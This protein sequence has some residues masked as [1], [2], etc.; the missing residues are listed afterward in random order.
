MKLKSLCLAALVAVMPGMAS[1]GEQANAPTVTG[2]TGLFT[3]VTAN[4]LR[5]GDISFG[6]YAQNWRL[7]AA[8]ARAFAR[9]S[10][11]EYKDYGYD[12]DRVSASLG[13]MVSR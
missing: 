5:R 4:T 6:I 11:R 2:E 3:T 13:F 7:T 8:P 10:A 1:A 9:P 12:L